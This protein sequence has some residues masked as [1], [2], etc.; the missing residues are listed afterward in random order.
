MARI[1]CLLVLCAC[2]ACGAAPV[3]PAFARANA[4]LLVQIDGMSAAVLDSYL[5]RPGAQAKDRLLAQVGG[6]RATAFADIGVDASTAATTLIAEASPATLTANTPLLFDLLPGQGTAA[7]FPAGK[8][9]QNIDAATD[10]ARVDAVL[11]APKAQLVAVRFTGLAEAQ[12]QAGISASPAALATIDAHLARLRAHRP[13]ALLIVVGTGAAPRKVG[14]DQAAAKFA[15]YLKVS[16]DAVH[17]FGGALRVDGLDVAG[18]A[19]LDS[20]DFTFAVFH[21]TA[22]GVQVFDHDLKALRAV[23]ASEFSQL[24][25]LLPRLDRA[26]AVGQ[27]LA[28]VDRAEGFD[29]QVGEM[30]NKVAHG[31]AGRAESTVPILFAGR[32]VR[33]SADGVEVGDVSGLIQAALAGIDSAAWR[34]LSTRPARACTDAKSCA[35]VLKRTLDPKAAADVL[36]T[37]KAYDAA[38]WLDPSVPLPADEDAEPA[39]RTAASRYAFQDEP[40]GFV[41]VDIEVPS[42]AHAAMIARVVDAEVVA[43][44]DSVIVAV[45]HIEAFGGPAYFEGP[46]MHA[47]DYA[48]LGRGAAAVRRG[49]LEAGYA[50]LVKAKG[51]TPAAESWRTILLAFAAAGATDVGD[52]A[53]EYPTDLKGWPK[54]IGAALQIAD[55][56]EEAVLPPLPNGTTAE[57]KALYAAFKA[58]APQPLPCSQVDAR[59]QID[60]LRLTQATFKAAGLPDFAGRAAVYRA[61][62]QGDLEA[63]RVSIREALVLS[64]APG[65]APGRTTI[66]MQI[67]VTTLSRPQLAAT[68]A[69]EL[70][71]ASEA[72]LLWIQTQIAQARA[73]GKDGVSRLLALIDGVVISRQPDLLI[74]TVDFAIAGQ[75]ETA[76]AVVQALLASGGLASLLK[77]DAFNQLRVTLFLMERALQTIKPGDGPDE[78]VARAMPPIV[79]AVM[80]ALQGAVPQARQALAAADA[81]L[82]M[83]STFAAREAA[84]QAAGEDDDPAIAAWGPLTKGLIVTGRLITA[85]MA[86]DLKDGQNQALSLIELMRR[87]AHAE[88]SRAQMKGFE[89]PVDAL[90]KVLVELARYAMLSEDARKSPAATARILKAARAFPLD[91]PDVDPKVRPW[92]RL[93]GIAVHD[94]AWVLAAKR[95]DDILTQPIAAMD[96]LVKDWKP[97]SRLGGAGLF[98]LLATQ[99]ALPDLGALME[100][101][102]MSAAMQ[103]LPR[104]RAALQTV[105]KAVRDQYP[106]STTVTA[107][108]S[109]KAERIFI[110]HV[111]HILEN[112]ALFS[113]DGLPEAMAKTNAQLRAAAGGTRGN[114]RD[115]LLLI[116]TL[117]AES[118]G[119]YDA[120]LRWAKTGADS[121][122]G[123]A[124]ANLPALWPGI[125]AGINTRKGDRKAAIAALKTASA[126]CP[127]VGH[128]FTLATA[129]HQA[130]S[131]NTHGA[132]KSF[133]AARLQSRKAGNGGV[134]AVFNLNVQDDLLILQT[135][136][137]T[138]ALGTLLGRSN[139]SF[140]LGA[141]GTSDAK[142]GR[143]IGWHL[144]AQSNPADAAMEALT[145]QAWLALNRGDYGTAGTALSGMVS[146]MYGIDPR[147]IDGIPATDLP[148][149]PAEGTYFPRSARMV[150]WTTILA[151]QHGFKRLA[152]TLT[153]AIVKNAQ[154]EWADGPGGRI[155]LCEDEAPESAA[156]IVQKLQCEAPAPLV[157]LMGGEE[158]ARAMELFVRA[159]VSTADSG[160]SRQALA[161]AVP[162]SVPRPDA[163]AALEAV[164]AGVDAEKTVRQAI[165]AGFVCELLHI[166]RPA[167]KTQLIGDAH[168]CGPLPRRIGLA[169]AAIDDGNATTILET[170]RDGLRIENAIRP[171]GQFAQVAWPMA[172]STMSAPAERE[173]LTARA[174]TWRDLA[175]ELDRPVDA[176][177]FEALRLAGLPMPTAGDAEKALI[178]A[179][180]AG[181]RAGPALKFFKQ[182]MSGNSA[183]AKAELLK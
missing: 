134:D 154:A 183:V 158:A 78:R 177:W 82:P 142:S 112:P 179:W 126:A 57:Q 135:T 6:V 113:G 94:V 16:P 62:L 127:A 21:R 109:D 88:L 160:A 95:D 52:D 114:V 34:R 10:A 123:P 103:T 36:V 146:V 86:D 145:L 8:R 7:G 27:T 144:A 81:M 138:P 29:F 90:S 40:R 98:L 39:A 106:V 68:L 2:F 153:Q 32:S 182:V 137:Q 4:V 166:D 66:L 129:V 70:D 58:R 159:R 61:S 22:A 65:A 102:D 170:L 23:H 64:E 41:P 167:V 75:S 63:A 176:A 131:G 97:E 99:H 9:A 59:T 178:V 107:M 14:H 151:E 104:V 132:K 26:L 171:N 148:A 91:A 119:Q 76:A 162:T 77:P 89:A 175:Q 121:P 181:L 122:T 96:A 17:A 105:V 48:A 13:N 71:A 125:V 47:D 30:P 93:A 3:A 85:V 168:V 49:D 120:A 79:R 161:D 84:V 53:P 150:L 20:I 15:Q 55:G 156:P 117:L 164:N 69:P 149:M 110:E 67:L 116:E 147:H 31:G 74:E 46:L 140:Q 54:V 72:Q 139:G 18:V 11:A 44:R 174:A 25:A 5:R 136:I 108:R 12:T 33:G 37:A 141:G 115:I 157:H 43:W 50:E 152:G 28:L 80:Y 38:R 169:Q 101:D 24:P 130:A 45:P 124:F 51:H 100:A 163:V 118:Q 173:R 111:L 83:D 133:K 60:A 180:R 42:A 1:A 128:R 87:F 19:A 92:L 35:L 165:E 56:D 172:R 73:Q 155:T 143:V